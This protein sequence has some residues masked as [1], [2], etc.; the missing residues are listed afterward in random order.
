MTS[1]E[2]SGIILVSDG[3]TTWLLQ[4]EPYLGAMISDEEYYPTPVRLVVFE[5]SYAL[6]VSKPEELNIASLWAVHPNVIDRLRRDNK[7]IE[8]KG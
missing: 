2:Q 8:E 5:S 3:D 6:H 1:E 7:L 4:G